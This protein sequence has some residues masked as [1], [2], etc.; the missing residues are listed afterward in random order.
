MP[1]HHS[2]KR[3][4]VLAVAMWIT[5]TVHAAPATAPV[6]ASVQVLQQIEIREDFNLDFGKIDRPASGA[7]TF[8]VRRQGGTVV[9][10][11][12]GTGGAFI[13]GHRVGQYDILG[14]VNS[15]VVL[16]T[17]GGTCSTNTIS[18][19]SIE[20][21]LP[22]QVTLPI[23]D[24]KLGGTLRVTSQ[25]QPGQHTCPYTLTARYQ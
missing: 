8:R 24:A 12:G 18:L 17:A 11:D 4:A 7:Q 23:N 10:D 16:F 13:A 14:S 6:S 2:L 19:V 22:S 9:E 15:A 20:L 5:G 1:Q 3:A 21:G 25:S